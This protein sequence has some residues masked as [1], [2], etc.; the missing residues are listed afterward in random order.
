MGPEVENGEKLAKYL[1]AKYALLTGSG[2]D[3]ILLALLAIGIKRGDEVITTP[4]SW[5]TS[6][7]QLLYWVQSQFL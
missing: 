7:T 4:L 1:N 6:A 3:S 2:T 5:I